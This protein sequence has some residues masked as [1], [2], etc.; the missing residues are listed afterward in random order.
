MTIDTQPH[1]E[2]FIKID[3]FKKKTC[4]NFIVLD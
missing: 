4:F 1:R 3:G 2:E